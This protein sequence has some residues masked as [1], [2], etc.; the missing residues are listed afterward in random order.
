MPTQIELLKKYAL[1]VRGISGQHLLIDPNT[2]RKIV[3]LVDPK[4]GEKILEIGPGLGALTEELLARG[5]HVVAVEKDKRFVEILKAEFSNE[6]KKGQLEIH[7]ADILKLDLKKL[8]KTRHLKVV[9]N[10]PYYITAPILFHLF[11]E[12]SL[13]SK[14]I[15]MMQK[16]VAA[17]L[18]AFPGSKDYGR[19]TLATRYWADVEHALDVSPH[20]FT[21]KPEVDS[22]VLTLH[23]HPPAQLPKEVDEK[24]LFDLTGLAFS[25]R[26][27][28]LLHHL[29]ASKKIG[30]SRAAILHIFDELGFLPT[31]RG[32]ELLLK[33]F[34]ALARALRKDHAEN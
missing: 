28:T 18:L 7:H 25:Q 30:L 33:D 2:Q 31:V 27:K 9:S 3:D 29:A 34:L 13:F 24:F 14:A 15:L 17:R 8:L 26:R 20:C 1:P 6:V 4:P 5:A 19:L 22:T 32:E 11:S 12:H 16:E 10:L 23:F 21:P